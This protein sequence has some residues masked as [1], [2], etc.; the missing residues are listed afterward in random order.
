MI[1]VNTVTKLFDETKALDNVSLRMKQGGVYGLIGSNGSGKSTLLRIISGVYR[2]DGGSVTIEGENT[3]ENTALKDRI[4]FV[5]D[6]PYFFNQYSI[7]DAAK[8]Y[9]Q[10]YSN[11]DEATFK[12]LCEIFPL[13]YK[14]KIHTFSKGMKRQASLLLA[15]SANPDYLLLDEAFDGLDAVIRSLLK[16][17]IAEKVVDKNLTTVI[18][19]HNLRELEDLCTQIGLLHYGKLVMERDYDSLKDSMHKVQLAFEQAPDEEKLKTLAPL[20]TEVSGRVA[21]LILRGEREELKPKLDELNPIFIEMLPLTL[22]E[23]F[24]Y[25]MEGTGY[26]FSQIMD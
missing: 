10:Y 20:K 16:R 26:D 22:E 7:H 4:F 9:R 18:T 23:I 5:S 25:E 6:E 21:T 12:R 24:L 13:N 15:L 14:K 2:A 11:W 1:E 17:I 3:F 8:F 19:S